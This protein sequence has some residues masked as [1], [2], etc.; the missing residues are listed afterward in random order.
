MVEVQSIT[1]KKRQYLVTL[2]ID[3]KIETFE[4]SEEIILDYRLVRG[5]QLDEESYLYLKERML[6]DKYRQKLWHYASY[7]PRT[8]Q[9]ARDYLNQFSMPEKAKAKYI[10]KLMDAHIL[11]DDVYVRNYIDEYSH[12]RMIGPR[13]I[14]FN[15]IKK[16]IEKNIIIQYIGNYDQ[17]LMKENLR[18]LIEKKVKS[19]KNK[20]LYK[21]KESIKAYGVNKGYDYDLVQEV[22][23]KMMATI[24][25]NND[26]NSAIQKDYDQYV[27]KFKKSSQSQT[28]KAYIIPKLMQKGYPYHK[29]I[30]LLEGEEAYED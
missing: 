7:K 19:S 4:L 29:I 27:S 16:G 3:E 22:M 2:K 17:K 10:Q 12:F 6:H 30:Q 9:E 5:K 26:E 25:A 20:P 21:A 18:K 24:L 14:I 13:K 8:V 15:L 1:R 23:E 28:L 11:D